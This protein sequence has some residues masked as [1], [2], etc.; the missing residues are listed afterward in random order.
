MTRPYAPSDRATC[1]RCGRTLTRG[2]NTRGKVACTDCRVSD[3]YG[4]ALIL[5]QDPPPPRR[6]KRRVPE[7]RDAWPDTDLRRAA[8]DYKAGARDTWT[9]ERHREYHRRHSQRSRAAKRD[10]A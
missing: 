8:A 9:I 4:T 2:G 7:E 10:A 5:G 6:A 1:V 3:P